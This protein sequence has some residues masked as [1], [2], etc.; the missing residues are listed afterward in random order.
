M[1]EVA[2]YEIELGHN[3]TWEEVHHTVHMLQCIFKKYVM[4]Y[5][6]AAYCI[7]TYQISFHTLS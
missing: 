4:Q 2:Q 3:M 5:G 6:T 1:T 7:L